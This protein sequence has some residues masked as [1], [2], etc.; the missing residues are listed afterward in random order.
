MAD[1]ITTIALDDRQFKQG[2]QR[3]E[4]FTRQ[5]S[6]KMKEALG[7]MGLGGLLGFGGT[8]GAAAAAVAMTYRQIQAGISGAVRMGDEYGKRWAY[9]NKMM[10]LQN[11]QARELENTIGRMV[12]TAEVGMGATFG[13]L[14]STIDMFIKGSFSF[15][16]AYA[17]VM[18]VLPGLGGT[19]IAVRQALGAPQAM[20]QLMGKART[21]DEAKM[22]R[23]VGAYGL[24]PA[25]FAEMTN[26]QLPRAMGTQEQKAL[27]YEKRMVEAVAMWQA[28]GGKGKANDDAIVQLLRKSGMSSEDIQF[29]RRSAEQLRDGVAKTNEI[30]KRIEA[31][32]SVRATYAGN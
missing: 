8:A 1:I 11:E 21:P 30:L 16:Q 19:G 27:D 9:A 22:M 17:D 23:P 12:F 18:S 25:R 10:E 3:T 26:T 14:A 24:S 4:Q 5:L 31:R 6:G 29:A 28:S 13:S 7:G 20:E 2:L 15:M 32:V